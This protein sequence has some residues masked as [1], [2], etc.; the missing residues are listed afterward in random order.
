MEG[1]SQTWY[2]NLLFFDYVTGSRKIETTDIMKS[3]WG[4]WNK[5]GSFFDILFICDGLLQRTHLWQI[6][7][8]YRMQKDIKNC[9]LVIYNKARYLDI[10]DFMINFFLLDVRNSTP[11]EARLHGCSRWAFE[12]TSIFRSNSGNVSKSKK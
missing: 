2:F 3:T 11:C 4:F 8:P 5:W 9:S 12:P 1:Q 10:I 7:K 6:E